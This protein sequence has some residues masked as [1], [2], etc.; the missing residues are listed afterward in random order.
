MILPS[1]YADSY[2][3]SQGLAFFFVMMT[4]VQDLESTWP[5]RRQVLFPLENWELGGSNF[6]VAGCLN[7]VF[8][9]QLFI[10]RCVLGIFQDLSLDLP[11]FFSHHAW[12]KHDLPWWHSSEAL[13]Y[14][15]CSCSRLPTSAIQK[16]RFPVAKCHARCIS[17]LFKLSAK[18]HWLC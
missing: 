15:L 4:S 13:L 8:K 2:R 14:Q 17:Q 10:F 5:Q 6:R 11:S 9:V 16:Q 1:W 12:K 3:V 7:V 18:G